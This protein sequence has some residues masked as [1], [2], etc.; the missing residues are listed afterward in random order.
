MGNPRN[1]T[2]VCLQTQ[3]WFHTHNTSERCTAGHLLSC[4]GIICSSVVKKA[5]CLDCRVLWDQVPPRTAPESVA[6]GEI[7]MHLPCVD[8]SLLAR[9]YRS[10]DNVVVEHNCFSLKSLL[11][12]SKF[13]NSGNNG[14]V[15]IH[16]IP[17]EGYTI[18]ILQLAYL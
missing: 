1:S 12:C 15:Y 14:Y 9:V 2:S 13:H 7:F 17:T 6:L 3:T 18:L 11:G 5:L 8:I 10:L 4:L 16:I